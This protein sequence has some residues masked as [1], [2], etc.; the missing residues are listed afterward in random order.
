[1]QNMQSKT[2]SDYVNIDL[3]HPG[4]HPE[5]AV[6]YLSRKLLLS[7]DAVQHLMCAGYG[8]ISQNVPRDE[9]NKQITLM[10]AI[11]MQ[12]IIADSSD[13]KPVSLLSYSPKI[14]Q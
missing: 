7:R 13:K 11:G 8:V 12:V 5:L 10:S 6:D 2:V 3:V 1:M 9:A 4:D 14:G